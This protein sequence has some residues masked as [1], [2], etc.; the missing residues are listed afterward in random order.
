[1]L[2]AV[3][4]SAKSCA[5]GSR[6]LVRGRDGKVVHAEAASAASTWQPLD[7]NSRRSGATPATETSVASSGAGLL[8]LSIS[9]S[10]SM[11][12]AGGGRGR[13]AADPPSEISGFGRRQKP[14]DS[15][16]TAL[17]KGFD[18]M[19]DDPESRKKIVIDGYDP[20]GFQLGDGVDVRG[21]IVCMPNSFVLWEPKTPSE[22]TIESLRILELVIPK[23]D[24]IILGV[25]ERM[26]ARLDPMLVKHLGSKGIRVEQ[27]DTVNACST[28]NVLNA[29]DRR[30]AAALLQLSPEEA[31]IASTS[32]G[33]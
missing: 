4:A 11:S 30:V 32:T 21:S 25:G 8:A 1:M 12:T 5:R 33:R 24:L 17:G 7:N 27:M 15:G 18:L 13:H 29:E 23:I 3:V 6:L 16:N 26:T 10:R 9:T 2:A 19:E 20:H 14:K 22:I 28:F 31:G